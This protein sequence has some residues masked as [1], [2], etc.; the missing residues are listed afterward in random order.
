MGANFWNT[1]YFPIAIT[2]KKHQSQTKT[3]FGISFHGKKDDKGTISASKIN[4]HF[5]RRDWG[6]F[7]G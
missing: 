5:A 3:E 2:S 4:D 6:E 1:L 7:Q